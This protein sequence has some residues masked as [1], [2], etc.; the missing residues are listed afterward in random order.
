[1]N[2][3]P[4]E[5]KLARFRRILRFHRPFSPPRA[6]DRQPY[7]RRP[8]SSLTFLSSEE[9]LRGL[10]QPNLDQM[11]YHGPSDL[12]VAA[13]ESPYVPPFRAESLME[14]TLRSRRIIIRSMGVFMSASETNRQRVFTLLSLENEQ[15]CAEFNALG[16]E[17]PAVKRGRPPMSETRQ[18]WISGRCDRIQSNAS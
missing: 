12:L 8:H 9:P 18:P 1:M 7:S 11:E 13:A 3:D 6:E 15:M 2:D 5:I 17:I 14:H 16:N 4:A 10:L